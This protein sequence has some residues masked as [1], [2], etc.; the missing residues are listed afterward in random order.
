MVV[1]FVYTKILFHKI[2]GFHAQEFRDTFNIILIKNRARCLA[3]VGARKAV[4]LLKNFFMNRMKR[5]IHQTWIFFPQSLQKFLILRRLLFGF[6]IELLQ[7]QPVDLK[8]S[9]NKYS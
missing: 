9:N 4:N 7:V 2:T 8:V 5:I 1:I 6:Y 3:A